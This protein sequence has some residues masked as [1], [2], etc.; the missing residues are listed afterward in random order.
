[1]QRQLYQNSQDVLNER[2]AQSFLE[3]LGFRLDS[4]GGLDF[5]GDLFGLM[6]GGSYC[7]VEY[8]RRSFSINKYPETMIHLTKWIKM[9]DLLIHNITPILL[10][11][12]SDYFALLVLTLVSQPD[13]M[14]I[15]MRADRGDIQDKAPMAFIKLTNF[16][17]WRK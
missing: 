14:Q 1:M 10:I 15:R 4:V 5:P 8:K 3:T 12:F 2:G 16:Q 17:V 9:K 6:P 13:Y 11:E 7:S